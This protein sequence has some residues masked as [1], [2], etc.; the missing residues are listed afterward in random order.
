MNRWFKCSGLAVALILAG[1]ASTKKQVSAEGADPEL[2]E[3][4]RIMTGWF[5]S[6]D[7]AASDPD[8]YFH[9]RLVMLPVMER[10]AD[11]KWLYVEQAA[12]SALDRPYRQRV[13]HLHRNPTGDLVSD[14]YTF[15]E[16]P[17]RFAGA[18]RRGRG[19]ADISLADLALRDGCSITLKR[20][21]RERYIGGTEGKNCVSTIRGAAYA[22]S[23][24]EITATKLESWDQGWNAND[25]QVWGATEGAYVFIKRGDAEPPKESEEQQQASH[26]S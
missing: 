13:Y 14:V 17:L 23:K 20:A 1:C 22:T 12:A 21:G 8:N 2:E 9:I 26:A 3:L 7:Q 11:G 19:L 18:W 15:K 10:R 24:V 5:D 6:A 16:D 25:E 4:A